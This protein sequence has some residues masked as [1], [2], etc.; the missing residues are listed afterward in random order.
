[1]EPTKEDKEKIDISNKFVEYS[2]MLAELSNKIM[3]EGMISMQAWTEAINFEAGFMDGTAC[4]IG[5]PKEDRTHSTKS[6]YKQGK[7]SALQTHE[8]NCATQKCSAS[9]NLKIELN[10]N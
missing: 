8:L 10:G 1:M 6:F 3:K 5:V 2:K 9:Q 7:Q 4:M